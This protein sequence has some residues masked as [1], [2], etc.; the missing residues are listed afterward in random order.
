MII[1][2]RKPR[3]DE[4]RPGSGLPVKSRA[5]DSENGTLQSLFL[6]FRA[7]SLF[8][9]TSVCP[10]F[11]TCVYAHLYAVLQ[12]ISLRFPWRHS[13]WSQQSR[14][15]TRKAHPHTGTASHRRY[16]PDGHVLPWRAGSSGSVS[17]VRCRIAAA[18]IPAGGCIE[19]YFK[20]CK[21]YINKTPIR[22]QYIITEREN[23]RKSIPAGAG[24]RQKQ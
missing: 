19:K 22:V 9:P 10:S 3:A 8:H 15:A 2:V 7:W 14:T 23:K 6:L 16:M 13:P 1:T 5:L 21:I 18:G 4:S 24:E 11:H 17:P 12:S 20:K